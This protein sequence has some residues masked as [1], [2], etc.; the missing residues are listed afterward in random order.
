MKTLFSTSSEME[1]RGLV[2][3]IRSRFEDM[4]M[5]AP[6]HLR[7]YR[8]ARFVVVDTD[9]NTILLYRSRTLPSEFFGQDVTPAHEIGDRDLGDIIRNNVEVVDIG[10]I[11][12]TLDRTK[13]AGT[14]FDSTAIWPFTF[15][16]ISQ[17][18][19][20]ANGPSSKVVTFEYRKG[21]EPSRQRVL[22]LKEENEDT[23]AGLDVMDEFKFK[24]FLKRRITSMVKGVY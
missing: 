11:K 12:I 14:V 16:T 19:E 15:E 3:L 5:A 23:I 7:D 4:T 17:I 6:G 9:S 24:R 1:T 18:N 20:A 10:S 21:Y 13:R 2:S 22:I 8:S